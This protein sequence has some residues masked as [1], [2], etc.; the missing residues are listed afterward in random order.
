MSASIDLTTLDAAKEY[1]HID[2]TDE[3]ALLLTL[4]NAA[5]EAIEHF[6]GRIFGSAQFT[7][8]HDGGGRRAIVLRHL[9]VL[10]VTSVHDD[11]ARA[12]TAEH[13]LAAD[14][15]TV[16]A[17]A[18]IIR[19]DAGTFADGRQNVKVICTAGYASVP[20]D[21]A[22]ACTILV[23]A[24]WERAKRRNDGLSGES[25]AGHSL[26]YEDGWP[27]AARRLLAPYVLPEV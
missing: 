16:D 15:Y 19:L 4:I 2:D 17:E 23:A 18:A 9:P 11:L 6:T 22:L 21:V 7:E 13:L 25:S 10:S 27:A 5:S 26:A 20:K 8:Y 1:L 14:E 12:F 24:Q 3:D